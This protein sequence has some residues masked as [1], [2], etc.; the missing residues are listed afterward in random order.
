MSSG[1]NVLSMRRND[2]PEAILWRIIYAIL[3]GDEFEE[4]ADRLYVSER[5]CRETW[6]IFEAYRTVKD[7][8]INVSAR[9]RALDSRNL[10]HLRPLLP[11]RKDWY[12]EE[13]VHELELASGN[14]VSIPTMWRCLCA[15]SVTHN[16][17]T[18]KAVERSKNERLL[19]LLSVGR[20]DA[21][22]LVFAGEAAVSRFS[23][24]RDWRRNEGGYGAARHAPIVRKKKKN[25]FA[26]IS[27]DG[28][29]S[30][31][32]LDKRDD[33]DVFT[34]W[35]EECLLPKMS[36]FPQSNS[37]LVLED[38][39]SDKCDHILELCI[40][41]GILLIF[42]P[43]YTRDCNPVCIL[44]PCLWQTNTQN[45][46][47]IEM[48]FFFLR[49]YLCR[50][51]ERLSRANEQDALIEACMTIQAE[52]ARACFEDCNYV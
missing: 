23:S 32:A 26:G 30:F 45:F 36:A 34:E 15:L 17:L 14:E 39:I 9:Q 38:P 31:A 46:L 2:H 29:I 20:F 10:V 16:M 47:Q 52:K 49:N 28:Y 12:L 8:F 44:H 42:M 3:D 35:L 51:K 37:V 6:A 7:P 25:V 4:V 33:D 27:L 21:E 5:V 41:A 24:E 13:L 19:F 50:H 43:P 40:N 11:I 18:E 22:L 1:I 48:S